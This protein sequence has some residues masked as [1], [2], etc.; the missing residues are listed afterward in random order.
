[1]TGRE[2]G[3]RRLNKRERGIT[4]T[5]SPELRETG[6]DLSGDLIHVSSLI[7]VDVELRD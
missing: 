1:M 3:E 7:T 6:E 2:T 4:N 5:G